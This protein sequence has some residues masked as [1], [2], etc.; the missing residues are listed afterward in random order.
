[1]QLRDDRAQIQTWGS[2]TLQ[3]NLIPSYHDNKE[4]HTFHLD[5]VELKEVLKLWPDVISLCINPV[6]NPEVLQSKP[7]SPGL[8]PYWIFFK[9]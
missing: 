2:W 8:L 6:G 4:Q 9:T 7:V 5:N 3:A 1:M